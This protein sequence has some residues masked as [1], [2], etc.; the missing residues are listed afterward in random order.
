MK[1]KKEKRKKCYLNDND[2]ENDVVDLPS[3]EVVTFEYSSF[4]YCHIAVFESM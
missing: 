1:R 4:Q 3:L 2:N